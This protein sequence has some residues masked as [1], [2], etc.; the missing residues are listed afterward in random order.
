MKY[1]LA[2]LLSL[3]FSLGYSQFN[4]QA[5][6]SG[7]ITFSGWAGIPATPNYFTS[8]FYLGGGFDT[9]GGNFQ[10]Y[11]KHLFTGSEVF[12][13]QVLATSNITPSSIIG[14]F[15]RGY[16]IDEFCGKLDLTI[17]ETDVFQVNAVGGVGF[18]GVTPTITALFNEANYFN[19]YQF[20]NL[21]TEQRIYTSS[22]IKFRWI[23]DIV[24]VDLSAEL[25]VMDTLFG[26]LY[27]NHR[28]HYFANASLGLTKYF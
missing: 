18:I 21:Q 24:Y 25:Y 15:N 8:G 14:E 26:V 12:S 20:S 10:I 1:L 11:Y 4:I 27:I 16:N 19:P 7:G 28:N 17:S 13:E 5:G 2:I 6:A 23:T 3:S 9:G 22:G